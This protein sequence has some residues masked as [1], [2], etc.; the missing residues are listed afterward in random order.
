MSKSS[1]IVHRSHTVRLLRNILLI[2]AV[3][4]ISLGSESVSAKE[5]TGTVANND[6]A[7]IPFVL[8]DILGPGSIATRT[9]N[10]GQFKVDL[11]NGRYT[12]RLRYNGRRREFPIEVSDDQHPQSQ[13]FETDW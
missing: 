11:L 6:G 7:G 3:I 8:V 10:D 1:G 2:V 5:F 13:T 4:L 9:N 12:V